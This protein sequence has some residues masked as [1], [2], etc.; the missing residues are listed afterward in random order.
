MNE[1]ARVASAADYAAHVAATEVLRDYKA[2][3]VET[4]LGGWSR[5]KTLPGYSV[6]AGRMVDFIIDQNL[7][8]SDG[9]YNLRETVNCP[10]TWFNMRMRAAIHGIEG[11][12]TGKIDGA[13][14]MEQKTP[15]FTYFQS[16]YPSLVGSEYLGDGVPFGSCDADGLRNEDATRLTFDDES[17]E[18]VMSFEVLE[19]IPDYLAALREVRRILRPGG[20]FYFTAPFNPWSHDHLIRAKMVDGK[21]VHILEP[22]WHG[23]PVRGEGI[24]C[25]Q[26]FGWELVSELKAGGFRSV[27]AMVF[28]QIEYGY[29]TREPILVFRAVAQ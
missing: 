17:F 29:Y 12:E 28:D 7:R 4:F 5:K 11:W 1:P 26:Q 18:L 2:G 8:M 22:E 19:H 3:I 24:L 15:L 6:P 21:V 10:E 27:E 23:D 25:F 16:R 9:S 13:Y 14:I 20:R